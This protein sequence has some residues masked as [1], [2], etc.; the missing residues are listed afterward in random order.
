MTKILNPKQNQMV[1]I[2]NSKQFQPNPSLDHFDF[3]FGY[4]LGFGILNLGFNTVPLN[5]HL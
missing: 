5:I 2:Q 1:K 3:E 4:Y